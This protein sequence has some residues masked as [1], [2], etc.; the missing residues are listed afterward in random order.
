MTNA[1]KVCYIQQ[2][3]SYVRTHE[4]LCVREWCCA[5]FSMGISFIL[6]H[7]TGEFSNL[8]GQMIITLAVRQIT[9]LN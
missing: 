2:T 5:K 7:S 8:I 3:A 6:Y 9:G 4:S 1:K